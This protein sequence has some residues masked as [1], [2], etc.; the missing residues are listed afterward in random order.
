MF[1]WARG[2]GRAETWQ[3]DAGARRPLSW[4]V[5]KWPWSDF[6]AEYAHA[7]AEQIR[8]WA[9]AETAPGRL[10]PWLPVAFGIGVVLYFAA[11]R[12]PAMWAAVTLVVGCAAAAILLRAWPIAFPMALALTAMAAGFAVA[13]LK[14]VLIAHPVLH[15]IAS[16][17]E[18]TG[19]VE[20]RE[21]RERSD[22]IVVRALKI[23]GGRLDEVPER[24][25]LSV[26]RGKIGRA[27]V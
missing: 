13:T 23:E 15:H 4:P 24:V 2:K 8:N 1:D 9:W 5:A 20:A 19:F 26:R 6:W 25:R 7:A 3:P 18:I 21:E 11:A 22:R 10:M 12:E 17:V 27:H 14:T 16:N